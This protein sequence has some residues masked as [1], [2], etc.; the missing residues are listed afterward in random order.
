ML[1]ATGLT[2]PLTGNADTVT[3][4]ANLTGIV[5]SVGNA[6]AIA[7]KAITIAKLADGTDG[8]LITW[9][10]AGVI[11]TVIT[12]IA[13]Q[14]LTSNGPDTAPTFQA[15]SAEVDTLQSV[16]DR[17]T[18]TS[19][20]ITPDASGTINLGT[21]VLAFDN[22]YIDKVHLEG[23]PTTSLQAATKQYV[24]AAMASAT[25]AGSDTQV[26]YN[27]GGV[28]GGAAGL[29][30]NDGTQDVTF[31]NDLLVTASGTQDLGTIALA[32]NDAYID[33][34]YLEANP[35]TPFQ[36]ATKQYV[37]DNSGGGGSP[38]GSDTQIQFND[39]GSFSG[40]SDLTWNKSTNRMTVN[41]DII[42]NETIT[43]DTEYNNGN[44]GASITVDWNNGNK[45]MVTMT[46]N[47]TI[48]FTAPPGP[49]N[50]VLR[51]VQDAGG[52]N[53]IAITGAL[54]PDGDTPTFSTGGNDVDIVS[55]YYNGTNY[56][57]QTGLNFG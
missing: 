30:Y 5:T 48:G 42:A 33:K 56:Y 6:T 52:T 41:G 45:Q 32:F 23:N 36:A 43:Y 31:G 16:T 37:D 54:W 3:T 28:M 49:S 21:V 39:G 4:N 38:G 35:T 10:A 1:T 15:S 12:G 24:D 34:V 7:D 46:A 14:V 20:V 26:Q 22:A 57:C 51:L 8:E 44:S 25:P 11:A 47:C 18:T 27:N 53:T 50:L 17:G 9:D 40:D 13:N 19:N 55:I 29:I 2:G